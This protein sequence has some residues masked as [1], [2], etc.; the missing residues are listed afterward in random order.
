LDEKNLKNRRLM[1]TTEIIKIDLKIFNN[2][3]EMLLSSN[4][5]DAVMAVTTIK[6]MNPSDIII[7]FFLKK[8]AYSL[9]GELLDCINEKP[10][11]YNDLTLSELYKHIKNLEN[12]NIKNIKKI[13]ESLVFEHFKDLTQDYDFIEANH[14]I[15]W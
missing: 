5:E 9:R 1:D 4:R 6:N 10:W 14:K 15:K 7:R 2:L 3:S 11:T 8:V 13:Y 12:P